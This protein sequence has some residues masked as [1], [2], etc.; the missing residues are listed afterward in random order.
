MDGRNFLRGIEG[1]K[2]RQDLGD[3][4][5]T[6]GRIDLQALDYNLVGTLWNALLDFGWGNGA[7]LGPHV[8]HFQHC[9]RVEWQLACQHLVKDQSQ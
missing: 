4:L 6:V 7:F 5:I 1:F 9:L 8:H 3:T 2:V